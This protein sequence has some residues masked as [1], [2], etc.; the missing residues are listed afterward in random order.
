MEANLMD[1]TY[2]IAA[3]AAA[4]VAAG[5]LAGLLG[6]GGGIVIVPVLFSSLLLVGV[7][8]AICMHIAVGTSLM[9]IVATSLS[10]AR[11]HHRKGAIDWTLAKRWALAI[12]L[13]AVAGGLIAR[14]LDSQ[15]LSLFFAIVAM[16][17]AIYLTVRK[18]G[19]QLFSGLPRGVKAQPIPLL[20]GFVSSLIGIGGGTFTVPV[21]SSCGYPVRNAVAT[22]SFFGLLISLPG[23]LTFMASGWGDPRLPPF[24]LGYVSLMGFVI[25]A[26][27]TTLAAPWGA[28]LAHAV[29]PNILRRLFAVFLALTAIKMGY[30]ALA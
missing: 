17:V 8:P 12:A 5:M 14:F 29:S 3:L 18:E 9:T 7:D 11:A 23:A 21:L 13:G 19:T 20:I 10:S 15:E 6:V 24:S 26:P 16:T 25:I 28:R 1:F 2:L 22:S 27:L 4:G 30:S